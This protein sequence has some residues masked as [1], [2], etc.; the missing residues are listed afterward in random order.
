MFKVKCIDVDYE[1]GDFQLVSGVKQNTES[2]Y[3]SQFGSFQPRGHGW[4]EY[5]SKSDIVLTVE[6]DEFE[7]GL[8][9]LSLGEFFKDEWGRL[10]RERQVAI[11]N[12]MPEMVQVE[13]DPHFSHFSDP[14][15]VVEKDLKSW[16]E[17]AKKDHKRAAAFRRRMRKK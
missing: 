3:S 1:S 5:T 11:I 9:H 17:R 16:L 15:V 12:T 7:D 13:N 6:S 2:S 10:S 4:G 8:A 14:Y